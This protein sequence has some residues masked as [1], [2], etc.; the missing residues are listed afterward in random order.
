MICQKRM[1]DGTLK[2][3]QL[4]IVCV[5]GEGCSHTHD[6]KERVQ[7]IQD[8]IKKSG[9]NKTEMED[10]MERGEMWHYIIVQDPVKDFG[11]ALT[12]YPFGSIRP[13]DASTPQNEEQ[14]QDSQDIERYFDEMREELNES[15][16]SQ[17]DRYRDYDFHFFD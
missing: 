16:D 5:G 4:D 12:K 7:E 14:T 15:E 8:L 9:D 13:F 17:T 11:D 6:Y 3:C 1:K 2:G 10:V